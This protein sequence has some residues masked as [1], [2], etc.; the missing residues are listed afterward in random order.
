MNFDGSATSGD[1]N[2]TQATAVPHPAQCSTAE[3]SGFF[4]A[5]QR[6]QT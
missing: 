1:G 6:E 5:E 3:F 2:V 4:N